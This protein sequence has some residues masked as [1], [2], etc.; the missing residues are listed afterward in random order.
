MKELKIT[1]R[2]EAEKTVVELDGSLDAIGAQE[3]HN[4]V[5]GMTTEQMTYVVVDCAKLEYISSTG[6]RIFVILLKKCNENGG[7]VKIINSN[8]MVKE[9]FDMTDFSSLF[10]L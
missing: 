3:F 6:L 1:I 5:N 4:L 2:Q 9:V 10:G 7:T 8:S